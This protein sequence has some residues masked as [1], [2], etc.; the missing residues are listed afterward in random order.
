MTLYIARHGE[1]DFN[2]ED[3]IQ[4]SGKDLSVL[5]QRGVQQ[6]IALGKS[7]ENVDFDA[8]YSSPLR[9][10]VDTVK[11]AFG[12]KYEP[13]LDKR[14]IEIGLGE[15]EGMLASEAAAAFPESSKSWPNPAE[16]IPP[17]GGEALEDMVA[18]VDAFLED[19]RQTGHRKVLVLTHG[20]TLR[21]F[22][23]CTVDKSLEAIGYAP[24]YK[25]C[26]VVRYKYMNDE[27]RMFQH[28]NL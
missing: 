17:P 7:L 20:Y 6:A 28:E 8:V 4:G 24:R 11:H 13:I 27:W 15:M 23:A 2:A 10:A 21:V 14:L 9:R 1:T 5:S 3:R 19:I 18:R 26:E 25:N 22:Y 16:Y 12:N